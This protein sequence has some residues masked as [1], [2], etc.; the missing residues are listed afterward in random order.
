MT[1]TETEIVITSATD[2]RFADAEHAL[3]GGGDGASCQ[4]QW[5]MMPNAEFQ[6]RSVDERREMLHDEMRA[7]TPPALIAYVDGTAAGWVRV[8]P[9]PNQPRLARTK[10]IGP[11]MQGEVDDT[12]IWA[13][14]CF[15]VRREFRSRGLQARLLAAAVAFARSHGASAIEGYPI[16]TGIGRHPVNDLYHGTLSAFA[17]QGFREVARPKPDRVVVWID[18][19]VHV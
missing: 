12:T 18:L 5:W 14:T 2:D 9:R 17:D 10:A 4:C 8:G 15:V 19:T 13:V 16:D 11:G 6:R 1:D 3:T 7:D